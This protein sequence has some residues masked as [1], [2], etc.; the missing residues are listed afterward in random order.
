MLVGDLSRHSVIH[1]SCIGG[2]VA[3]GILSDHGQELL[4]P[5]ILPRWDENAA[6]LD[7]NLEMT[8][9]NRNDTQ[10]HSISSSLLFLI[11]FYAS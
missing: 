5:Q 7:S 9:G 10:C 2:Y 1:C 8:K 6:Q 4:G 11:L 3:I